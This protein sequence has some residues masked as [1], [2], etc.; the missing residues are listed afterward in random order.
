MSKPNL[1]R[2]ER[3]Q[4]AIEDSSPAQ[5]TEETLQKYAQELVAFE[6]ASN[7]R[8]SGS[9]TP[10]QPPVVSNKPTSLD[11]LRSET[12]KKS[13]LAIKSE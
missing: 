12:P 10:A 11:E 8:R 9:N 2:F 13:P 1:L 3:R 7:D 4:R 5:L 6:R